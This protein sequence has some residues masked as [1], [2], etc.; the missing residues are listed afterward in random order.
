M[1][2]RG[3]EET[4]ET[5]GDQKSLANN[6]ICSYKSAILRKLQFAPASL[7]FSAS[8]ERMS[9]LCLSGSILLHEEIRPWFVKKEMEKT[10]PQESPAEILEKATYDD[11]AHDTALHT[12]R[13]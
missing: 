11:D 8:F 12:T 7:Q 6:D 3:E 4:K 10:H 9:S 5:K 2:R 13:H 1:K